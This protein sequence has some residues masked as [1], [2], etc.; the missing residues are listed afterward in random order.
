MK[1][2]VVDMPVRFNIY[3]IIEHMELSELRDFV[4]YAG[5]YYREKLTECSEKIG[6]KIADTGMTQRTK[7]VCKENNI[8]TIEQLSTFTVKELTRMRGIGVSIIYD[9]EN[10]MSKLGLCF[11]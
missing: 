2:I 11:K 1:E 6:I 5:L 8:F 9:M 4:Y 3:S 7:N 10:E